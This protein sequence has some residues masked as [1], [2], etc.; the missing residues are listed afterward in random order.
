MYEKGRLKLSIYD[1]KA[2]LFI[3]YKLNITLLTF[4]LNQDTI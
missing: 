4:I 3:F 2:T 1:F